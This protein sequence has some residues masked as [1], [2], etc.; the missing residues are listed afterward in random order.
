[1]TK[2]MSKELHV[3]LEEAVKVVNLIRSAGVNA[4]LFSILCSQ[5]VAHCQHLLLRTEVWGLSRVRSSPAGLHFKRKFYLFLLEISCPLVKHM[6]D[7]SWW[8]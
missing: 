7:M 8:Q 6:E 1:M 2:E 3:V 5:M 4:R